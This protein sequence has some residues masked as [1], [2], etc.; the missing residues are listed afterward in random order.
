MQLK[1]ASTKRFSAQGGDA[2]VPGLEAVIHTA[3]KLGVKEIVIGMPHRGRMNV[4]TTI[5]GKP[6]SELLRI[7][8]G[9]LHSPESVPT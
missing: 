2:M 5:M 4:L 7:F 6:Y 3:S 8:K 9:N 1:Y